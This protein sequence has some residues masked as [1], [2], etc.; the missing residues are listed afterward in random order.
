MIVKMKDSIKD[1]G[2]TSRNE[3]MRRRIRGRR[4]EGA[5]EGRC[6]RDWEWVWESGSG[7]L[8]KDF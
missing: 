1:N 2:V 8:G 6:E 3:T 7:S 5:R 4:I